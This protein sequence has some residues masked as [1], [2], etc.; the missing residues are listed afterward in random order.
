[1]AATVKEPRRLEY[2]RLDDVRPAPRNPKAHDEAFLDGTIAE[3][4]FT[5]PVLL[6]ERTGRLVVGHG[7]LDALKRRK[8]AGDDPPEGIVVRGDDWLLPVVRGWSSRDDTHAAGYLIVANRSPERGGWIRDG[9]PGPDL[10]QV[11]RRP[12]RADD[13]RH[14]PPVP[15]S[16]RRRASRLMAAMS[17]GS[18]GPL[19]NPS[20]HSR[21]SSRVSSRSTARLAC[22][23]RSASRTTSLVEA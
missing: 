14:Q 2:Q 17:S 12:R 8:A 7:R 11:L 18:D 16:A 20:S 22:Q 23:S 19:A 4:G 9:Y 1:M 15:P 21:R 6:D 5:E 13:P 10:Q 3:Y